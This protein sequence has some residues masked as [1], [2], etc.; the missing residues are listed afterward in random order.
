LNAGIVEDQILIRVSDQ[1]DGGGCGHVDHNDHTGIEPQANG[2]YYHGGEGGS[3]ASSGEFESPNGTD[4]AAEITVLF[5]YSSEIDTDSYDM[6]QIAIIDIANLNEA[7]DV[8]EIP[9]TNIKVKIVGIELLEGYEEIFSDAEKILN[10][11]QENDEL[12]DLRDEYDADIV[13]LF[14]TK[15]LF[16]VNPDLTINNNVAGAAIALD[17][18]EIFKTI[19]VLDANDILNTVIAHE[20]G[21]IFGCRHVNG[22]HQYANGHEWQ[23]TIQ[24]FPSGQMRSTLM[25]PI[26]SLGL[27]RFSNPDVEFNGFPTGTTGEVENNNA[28]MIE[29]NACTISGFGGQVE[30][31]Y[32]DPPYYSFIT[33]PDYVYGYENQNFV[34]SSLAYGCPGNNECFHWEVSWNG[35]QSFETAIDS[36]GDESTYTLT[37]TDIPNNVPTII[38][39]LTSTC[40]ENGLEDVNLHHVFNWNAQNITNDEFVDSR[41]TNSLGSH[42]TIAPNPIS[43]RVNLDFDLKF[44]SKVLIRLISLNGQRVTLYNQSLNKGSQSLQLETN[45]INAGNYLLEIITDREHHTTPIIIIK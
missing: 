43:D 21:H 15:D 7:L 40:F 24:G 33:G 6:E 4:C 32:E 19:G 26:P 18:P 12:N 41:S 17:N 45:N 31:G 22:G 27:M 37:A 5:V 39:K 20:I 29:K 9:N 30:G 10:D 23:E 42:F 11:L 38:L 35:G 1:Y 25:N 2:D 34:W 28:R 36:D 14:Q 13:L 3:G 44:D 16:I 8:S